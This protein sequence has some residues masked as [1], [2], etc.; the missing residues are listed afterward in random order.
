MERLRSSTSVITLNKRVS[1][2]IC[3]KASFDN[4]RPK[5]TSSHHRILEYGFG[6]IPN[7][8]TRDFGNCS[9]VS[10]LSIL[11]VS[12]AQGRRIEPPNIQFKGSQQ[13][14]SYRTLQTDKC[15][16][17]ARFPSERRL[18]LQSGSH[19]S[20][21]PFASSQESQTLFTTGIQRRTATNDVSPLRV[22]YSAKGVRQLDQLDGPDAEKSRV[23]SN[24][25]PRRF[26][27]CS[28]GPKDFATSR[29]STTRSSLSTRM[30]S[31]HRKINFKTAEESCLPRNPLGPLVKPKSPPS[32]QNCFYYQQNNKNIT[33]WQDKPKKLTEL[34]RTTELRKLRSSER[35]TTLSSSSHVPKFSTEQ[36]NKDFQPA[37]KCNR[38][39]KVVAC[40]LSPI[41]E[42]PSAIS[43]SLC[44]HG[45]LRCGLGST[46]RRF[47][48]HGTVDR[49]RETSSLQ[50]KRDASFIKDIRI[51][52]RASEPIVN[53]V[54][55]RQSNS[56]VIFEKPRWNSI[57]ES[58]ELNIQGIS[59]S[60]AAPNRFSSELHTGIIQ[61]SRRSLIPAQ[62]STGVASRVA[63]HGKDLSEVRDTSSGLI[64]FETSTRS[65]KLRDSRPS[66]LGSTVPQ[67]LFSDLDLPPC[68]DIS[69]ALPYTESSQSPQ[70][71]DR[72]LSPGCSSMASG[73]LASRL[74]VPSI[75]STLHSHGSRTETDRHSD[76]PTTSQG[77]TNDFGNMEVWGWSRSLSNWR[78]EQ[79]N[80]L[81]SSWRP[82]TRR[83]YQAAWNRWLHW[84]KT[85]N[86]DP[87]NPT[88]PTLAR[89]LA[90]LHIVN[91]LS[92]NTVLLHKSVV[93]T[94]C[95]AETAGDLSS[96]VLVR[97]ILK[98]IALNKPV[99]Q[100]PPVWNIDQLVSYLGN[101][102]VDENSPFAT[103]RH[104][105]ALL[106]L[107]SGRRVHDL[108]L[109][110]IDSDHLINNSDN[111]ILWPVFGSKTDN[112]DHRQSGWKLMD[113]Q[114]NKNL[115]PVYWVRKTVTLLEARRKLAKSS[116]LFVTVRG[117]PKPASRTIIAGW[118]KT[119]L[120]E[121]GITATPGSFRS[122]VASR[123][124]V[125]NLPLD[126]ILSRG[127]W[128]SGSTFTRFYRREILPAT[129][130]VS[131]NTTS[132]FNPVD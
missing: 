58:D 130:S 46:N 116:N 35:Q 108:T 60:G 18:A 87:L 122:A 84:A 2:T 127:N 27:G 50:S 114:E 31:E 4:A 29:Q 103:S 12:G 32:R 3:P 119:I 37:S 33:K 16:S 94:L 98:S 19:S 34:N 20:V 125:D 51:A 52:R 8:K 91:K 115:S 111:L 74:E 117:Q 124:W 53:P 17:S 55:V 59:L 7:E 63:S 40:R 67:C 6:H 101:V 42:D 1:H 81:Q 25:V 82:S 41:L 70:L 65:R 92:Y 112:S 69:S 75:D 48:C 47:T 78:P 68:V 9:K 109:L 99:L 36:S 95:N 131:S 43:T 93:A 88:G 121:A 96:H 22:E 86:E 57:T 118:I 45:C 105:A 90:D 38:G 129:A 14:H 30:E 49:A 72:N 24:C 100:K 126:D 64:C 44:D 83:T 132:L 28:S 39:S 120:K 102:N 54:S 89:F 77:P 110:A 23:T 128:R 85:T 123:N 73:I 15:F 61:Q 106:L 104:T 26:S 97:H 62:S 11:N 21:L 10:Q 66:R 113:N 71:S 5:R 13:V 76:G 79:L 80:L 107:C 56:S